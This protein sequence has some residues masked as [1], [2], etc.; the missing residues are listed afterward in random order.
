M[1]G[2]SARG[3]ITFDRVGIDKRF[4]LRSYS[5]TTRHSSSKLGFALAAPSFV[6]ETLSN[7]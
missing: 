7:V 3:I 6:M 5:V 1:E 2:D 4:D